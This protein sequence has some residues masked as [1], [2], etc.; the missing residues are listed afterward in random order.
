[1]L[2]QQIKYVIMISPLIGEAVINC[3]T[4]K[5]GKEV[6]FFYDSNIEAHKSIAEDIITGL[7]QF[8]DDER[9]LEHTDFGTE[10]YVQEVWITEEGLVI[11][12]LTEEVKGRI[13]Y[14][15]KIGRL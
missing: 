2:K 10:D 1:M 9:E 7:Q 4:V 12:K 15:P 11:E 6:P 13:L 8:I 14:D 5:D 3:W